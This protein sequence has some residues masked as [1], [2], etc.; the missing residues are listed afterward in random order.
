V[1]PSDAAP[2]PALIMTNPRHVLLMSASNGECLTHT[3]THTQKEQNK[4][5]RFLHSLK[6]I[7]GT[8]PCKT[9]F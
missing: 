1:S 3:H 2:S 6:N 5:T 9:L 7:T 4:T 8:C